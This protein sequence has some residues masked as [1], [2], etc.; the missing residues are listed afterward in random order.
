[1]DD[2]QGN[3][4]LYFLSRLFQTWRIEME[5]L[6]YKFYLRLLLVCVGLLAVV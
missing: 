5:V 4:F 3:S 1:M 2:L 6:R